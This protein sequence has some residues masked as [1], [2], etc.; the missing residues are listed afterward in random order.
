MADRAGPR[1]ERYFPHGWIV[2]LGA[3]VLIVAGCG[4]GED[5]DDGRTA[6]TGTET[7]KPAAPGLSGTWSGPVRQNNSLS[8]T[9]TVSLRAP[10][11]DVS[12]R[13]TIT[14]TG[15]DNEC[16]GELRF[17]T[18]KRTTQAH[19]FDARF[20]SFTDRPC[21]DGTVTLTPM[22]TDELRYVWR[23]PSGPL[24]SRGTLRRQ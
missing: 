18:L 15:R 5:V 24:S 7:S 8:F 17:A 4:V 13:S 21:L 2:T 6:A 14:L 9:I 12:N 19:R 16:S 1:H 3:W 22:G 23:A 20:T 10:V 11:A